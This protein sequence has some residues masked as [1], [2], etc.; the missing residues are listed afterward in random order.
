MQATS[1]NNEK[2]QLIEQIRLLREQIQPLQDRLNQIY[3]EINDGIDF[4]IKKALAGHGDFS[5]DELCFAA[6][7][8]CA[9]GAGMAYPDGG[10][11]VHGSWHCSA[12]LR[13][14]APVMSVHSEQMP[15][16]F[17]EIK[18]ENQPSAGGET[19]RPTVRSIN[20]GD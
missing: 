7:T 9:C 18:S 19:T 6:T 13:G 11:N 1:D 3:R 20:Q 4:R 15:F 17:Y 16:A 12:I 5:L 8:R 2:E 10:M 14:K